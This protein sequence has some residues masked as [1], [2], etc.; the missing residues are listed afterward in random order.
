MVR[1]ILLAPVNALIW[2]LNLFRYLAHVEGYRCSK[3]YDR[4]DFT[5]DIKPLR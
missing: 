4:Y 1:R 2:C 5:R 3:S